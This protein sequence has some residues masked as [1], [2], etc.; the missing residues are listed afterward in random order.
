VKHEKGCLLFDDGRRFDD[1]GLYVESSIHANII[2]SNRRPI[3]H[4]SVTGRACSGDACTANRHR[5][6]DTNWA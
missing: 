2:I 3:F 6:L 4:T 5:C 1:V